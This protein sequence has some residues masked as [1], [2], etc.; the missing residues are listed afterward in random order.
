MA[1]D[2]N[3]LSKLNLMDYSLLFCVSFNP[4]YVKKYPDLF[5]SNS[6]GELLKPYRLWN[7]ER[8]FKK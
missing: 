1:R 7:K 2:L 8:V 4:N 6:K 3:I 5:E